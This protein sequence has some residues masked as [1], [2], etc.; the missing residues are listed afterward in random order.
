ML[1]IYFLRGLICGEISNKARL[2]IMVMK[3]NFLNE[4]RE[5]ERQPGVLSIAILHINRIFHRKTIGDT[6][7]KLKCDADVSLNGYVI[8]QAFLDT[9]FFF[10]PTNSD[11]LR[12]LLQCA[13]NT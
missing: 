11:R 6:L 3:V 4:K 8:L 7:T 12:M 10:M 13:M 2:S 1:Y 9:H 5:R